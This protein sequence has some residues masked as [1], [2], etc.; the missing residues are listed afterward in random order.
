MYGALC[1]YAYSQ[2]LVRLTH[3]QTWLINLA[4]S[5]PTGAPRCR[6]PRTPPLPSLRSIMRAQRKK[7]E[8]KFQT[9]NQRRKNQR[10]NQRHNQDHLH[11]SEDEI[12]EA[13]PRDISENTQDHDSGRDVYFSYLCLTDKIYATENEQIH[14]TGPLTHAHTH[15]CLG[16]L[17]LL[18]FPWCSY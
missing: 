12:V 18:F 4:K 13:E 2:L 10:R 3:T 11:R 17:I 7:K 16:L 1:Q 5:R 8:R 14:E 15:V 9:I 6:S